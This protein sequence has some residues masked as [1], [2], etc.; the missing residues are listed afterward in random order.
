MTQKEQIAALTAQVAALT[1]VVNGM[2]NGSKGAKV[3]KAA[4]DGKVYVVDYF[5]PEKRIN[6]KGKKVPT[7]KF[8]KESKCILIY[9]NTKPI[10]DDIVKTFGTDAGFGNYF[11]P[12]DGKAVAVKGWLVKNTSQQ[13]HLEDI[14]KQFASK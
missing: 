14:K 6:S 1:A 13:Y 11:V 8:A 4:D 2:S 9:G 5:K 3:V 7:G 10:K 12:Q